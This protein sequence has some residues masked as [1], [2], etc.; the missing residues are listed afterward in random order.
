MDTLDRWAEDIVSALLEEKHL[1]LVSKSSRSNVVGRVAHALMER[2]GLIEHR[3]NDC[4]IAHGGV[5]VHQSLR[6]RSLATSDDAG[7]FSRQLDAK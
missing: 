4:G 1:E 6:A 3:L 7:C 2:D 5:R